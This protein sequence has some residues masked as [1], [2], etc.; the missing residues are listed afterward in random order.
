M[1]A[2]CTAFTRTMKHEGPGK[3]TN[4]KLDP[5]GMTYS[6]IS[7]VHWPDWEGWT[8][9]D[10]G[11]LKEAYP[12]VLNFYRTNFW[13]RIQGEEIS[14]SSVEIA[15]EI[16]DT[17]VNASVYKASKILQETLNL[18]N[19]NE[20]E[21]KD[22]IVDGKIGPVTLIALQMSLHSNPE[23]RILKVLNNLQGEH[24]ITLMRKHPEREEF[25]GWFDRV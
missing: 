6:G 14:K 2:F 18:L 3:L 11:R 17:A 15:C 25:R 4:N 10:M 23:N 22:L 1:N 9:V 8:L 24:Y 16:F 21:Y 12:M 5:G 7:R 19:R 13:Y 20:E